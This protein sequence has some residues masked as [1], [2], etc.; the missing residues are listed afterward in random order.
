MGYRSDVR[1]AT[2]R[3]AYE[4]IRDIVDTASESVFSPDQ[5]IGRNIAPAY[6]DEE[7]DTVVFGWDSICWNEG[8]FADVSNVM[9][10]IEEVVA[11]GYPLEFCR[12]GEEARDI[13]FRS[14]NNVG[15]LTLHLYTDTTIEIAYA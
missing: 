10:A 12:V 2:T 13:E 1:I 11:N 3:E 6:F 5:L 15:G 7:D 8:L 9:L 4:D 14:E